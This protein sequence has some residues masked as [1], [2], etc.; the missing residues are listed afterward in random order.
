MVICG[1][2]KDL[3]QYP[4]TPGIVRAQTKI[5]GYWIEELEPNLVDVH[6]IAET[7]FKISLF[8]QKQVGPAKSNYPYALM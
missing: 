7:D 5:S 4:P 3:D 8:I 6:F 1:R 2:S